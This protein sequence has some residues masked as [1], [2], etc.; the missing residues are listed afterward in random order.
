MRGAMLILLGLAVAAAGCDKQDPTAPADQP[1][2]APPA[3]AVKPTVATAPV[4]GTTVTTAISG[5]QVTA[6]GGAPVTAR[7]VVWSATP[8]PTISDNRTADGTGTGPFVSAMS[9][10]APGGTYY[11]RAYA[12]NSAGTAYGDEISFATEDGEF[13]VIVLGRVDGSP[14]LGNALNDQCQVAGSYWRGNRFG[15]YIWA[16]PTGFRALAWADDASGLAI[17]QAGTVAGGLVV[18][19][20]DRAFT[21]SEADGFRIYDSPAGF[22]YSYA[23][24]INIHGAVAGAS[25]VVGAQGFDEM[26]AIVWQPDGQTQPLRNPAGGW[27]LARGINDA[28]VVVGYAGDHAAAW[29]TPHE[30]PILLADGQEGQAWGINNQGHIVG[31]AG[32]HAALWR[33]AQRTLLPAL[34]GHGAATARALTEPDADGVIR[35]VGWSEPRLWGPSTERRAVM[36]TVDR[37]VQV[38]EL[39]LPA[40]H[41]GAIAKAIR[42][43]QGEVVVVGTAYTAD[44]ASAVMWSTSR[45]VCGS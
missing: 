10:L 23:S 25:A 27:A 43:V 40:G 12:T 2:E 9:G 35:V 30:N 33:G 26:A 11:V 18:E 13:A 36:W 19:Q 14:T 42:I 29:Q 38:T 7:G 28:G 45:D 39:Y 34:P 16:P 3:A 32:P 31:V 20:L 44:S 5:G 15:P 37:D 41:L 1:P 21:W 6:D 24:S 17:N 8:D 22:N 4:T